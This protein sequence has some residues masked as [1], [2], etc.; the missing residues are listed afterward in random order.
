MA[1]DL[2]KM[3]ASSTFY[4][5]TSLAA[6]LSIQR[7]GFDVARSGSNAGRRLGAGVYVRLVL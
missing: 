3:A 1:W 7:A 4:H 2:R 5:G 6:A